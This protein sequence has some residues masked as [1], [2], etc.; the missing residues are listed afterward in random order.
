MNRFR[1]TI[2]NLV[3]KKMCTLQELSSHSLDHRVK[4]RSFLLA[5]Y[6]YPSAVACQSRNPSII[7][8]MMNVCWSVHHISI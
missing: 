5:V 6:E 3:A 4:W 8:W 7:L 1:V 2:K